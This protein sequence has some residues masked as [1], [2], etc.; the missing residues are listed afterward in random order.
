M[1]T[2]IVRHIQ[3]TFPSNDKTM[4]AVICRQLLWRDSGS[5]L[6]TRLLLTWR[7]RWTVTKRTTWTWFPPP[8]S[9]P[10]HGLSPH[11]KSPLKLVAWAL[12]SC[13]NIIFTNH[14]TLVYILY[15]VLPLFFLFKLY[16]FVIH[17][18]HHMQQLEDTTI[19]QLCPDKWRVTEPQING[20]IQKVRNCISRV[21]RLRESKRGLETRRCRLCSGEC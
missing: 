18:S 8:P 4:C 15:S 14:I 19:L 11:T 16:L 13:V 2:V 21:L 10:S 9:R 1:F 3:Q 20:N 12:I 17:T 5:G 7:Y 6:P